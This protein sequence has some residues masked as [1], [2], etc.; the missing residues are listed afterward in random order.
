MDAPDVL[1]LLAK[2]P[3]AATA[4]RLT[5]AQI[6]AALTRARCRNVAETPARIQAALR[7]EQVG[8]PEVLTQAYA[9]T[10]RAAVAVLRTLD[11]QVKVLQGQVDAHCGRHRRR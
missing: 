10:T 5:I 2:A 7:G 6:S 1:E 9:A 3:E 11:E 8:Q 4:A